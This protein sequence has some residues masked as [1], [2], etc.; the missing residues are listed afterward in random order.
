[1]SL[2]ADVYDS[3]ACSDGLVSQSIKYASHHS[4]FNDTNQA[5]NSIILNATG[6]ILNQ[7]TDN[8]FTMAPIR[9]VANAQY[10]KYNT[11]TK[12][13]TY[14]AT[15]IKNGVFTTNAS[16]GNQSVTGVGFSSKSIRFTILFGNTSGRTISCD[17]R[18]DADGTESSRSNDMM[19]S[20]LTAYTHSTTSYCIS[21]V[22]A[23][24]TTSLQCAF[25][26]MNADGFTFD[27]IY[28][29]FSS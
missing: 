7:T 18:M 5:A 26:S 19:V 15:K 21:L 2:I 20:P 6:S 12:E 1:M 3:F 17:G 14:E 24:A 16:T 4:K 25:V 9:A 28:H 8:S 29:F 13:V 11:S 27:T 23:D 22:F 10:L